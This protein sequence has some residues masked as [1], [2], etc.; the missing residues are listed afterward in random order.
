VS[1]GATPPAAG[2]HGSERSPAARA[3]KRAFDVLGSLLALLV[4]GG[5]MLVIAAAIR[6]ESR[7]GAIFRQRRA[8]WRGRP[9][10]MLKFRTMRS[11]VE[12]YGGS[13]RSGDDPRLTRLGRLL[14]ETSLDELPQ[15]LNVLAGQMSLVGPRPLYERQ[16]ALWNER[17]RHRLDT[18]P[19]ITGYAQAFGRG[20]MTLEDKIEFDLYYVA[21]AS[22]P[23]DMTILVRTV[24]NILARRGGDVYEVR[25]SKEK[26]RESD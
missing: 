17:R 15:L 24:A 8:G 5:P 4:L 22:F 7:G 23:L 18:R 21:N 13:P 19:G 26:E 3:A 2:A 1:E 12:A 6:L 20:S 14:R 11:D 10:T 9:F 16:A 25:Y